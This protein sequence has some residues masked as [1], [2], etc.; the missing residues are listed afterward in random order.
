M[1]LLNTTMLREK[2]I[3]QEGEAPEPMIAAGNRITLP[4]ISKDGRHQERLIV[5]GHNMHTTLRMAAMI[6]R[7]FYRDGPLLTRSPSFPWG[8]NWLDYM[9]EHER[10]TNPHSWISIYNSGR[11][12]FKHGEYHP[13]LDVIEQCDA[14]NRDE[15][16]RAVSIAENAFN[17]AGRGVHIDHQTTIAMVIG[18]MDDKTRV[19]LIFRNPKRST[20]FNFSVEPAHD[21]ITKIKAVP[22]PH[23]CL[24]HAA[25]WLELVQLSVTA[26]FYR[27]K[28]G[29]A[30]NDVPTLENTQRRLGRLN[31]ELEQFEASFD[32]LYRP[33]RPNMMAL[34]DEAAAFARGDG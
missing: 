9:P 28:K 3:L 7:T 29:T 31:I 19:G 8:P 34:I 22:E 14:R 27:A 25:A 26:G 10:S 18:A 20:T 13:F 11:C 6:C 5:R 15:Y 21:S 23:Q 4:L 24:L 2:F 1:F 30:A 33:E 17:M 32:V 12:I 16:D